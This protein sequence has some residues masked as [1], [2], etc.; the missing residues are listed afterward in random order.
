MI[1]A[2]Q[3][4]PKQTRLDTAVRYQ[5]NEDHCVIL[6]LIVNPR[7][8]V[9]T[10]TICIIKSLKHLY[11]VSLVVKLEANHKASKTFN[12]RNTHVMKRCCRFAKSPG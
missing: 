9:F 6:V 5:S 8:S 2:S 1:N 4:F 3:V 12:I 10:Y 7:L 11:V